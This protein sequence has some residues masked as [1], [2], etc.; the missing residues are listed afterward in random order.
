MKKLVFPHVIL[1][2]EFVRLLKMNLGANSTAQIFEL[3]RANRG[4]YDVLDVALK[5][6]NDGRGLEKTMTA[7][8][9]ANFR[10]RLASLYVYKAIHGKYPLRTDMGLVEEI[11]KFEATFADFG[12]SGYSR[13]FLLGFYVKLA[14]IRAR[15]IEKNKFLEFELPADEILSVLRLSQVRSE[16]CDQLILVIH[17]LVFSLGVKAV[18]GAIV[19]GKT[20]D[21]L[22][23]LL[24]EES[25]KLM[26]NNLL[27]YGMSIQEP[28]F[29]LYEKV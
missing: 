9:W 19:A 14:E 26:Y 25:R 12:V 2:S 17:H 13:A 1:P 10:E 4:L 7:L 8:G 11:I 22:Y 15:E 29:F 5:E 27:S 6:F 20:F 28:E 3:L 18:T 23:A 21:D 24:P 16:K